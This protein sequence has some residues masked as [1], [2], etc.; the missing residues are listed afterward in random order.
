[1]PSASGELS[2][3]VWQTFSISVAVASRFSG[4]RRQITGGG[5]PAGSSTSR[6]DA[7]KIRLRE[8][9]RAR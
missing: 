8:T 3:S 4:W 7:T 5:V 1:M 2:P 9:C 6:R